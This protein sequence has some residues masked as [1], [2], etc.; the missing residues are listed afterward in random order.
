MDTR[1]WI[2]FWCTKTGPVLTDDLREE[3]TT[4]I[5]PHCNLDMDTTYEPYEYRCEKCGY[6]F[7]TWT[8]KEKTF[9]SPVDEDDYD[10]DD[11]YR[12]ISS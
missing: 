6:W 7:D 4:M 12:D 8:G 1:V 10:E 9:T 2:R 5:C 11:E 3:N